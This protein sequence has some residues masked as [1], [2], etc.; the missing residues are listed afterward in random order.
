MINQ[1]YGCDLFLV[2]ITSD[3]LP[4]AHLKVT[5]EHNTYAQFNLQCNLLNHAIAVHLYIA[6]RNS[7]QVL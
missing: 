2:I 7:I 1:R 3:N 4:Q 5:F 6:M